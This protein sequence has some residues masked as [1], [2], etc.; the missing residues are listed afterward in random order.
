MAKSL[1][2]IMSSGAGEAMPEPVTTNEPA[3]I[4]TPVESAA[5]AVEQSANPV[6]EKPA[7][8]MVPLPALQ[9]AR[10]EAREAREKALAIEAQ[11]QAFTQMMA[12]KPEPKPVPD[13]F[14]DPNGFVQHALDPVQSQIREIREEMSREFAISRHGKETV[15]AAYVALEAGMRSRDPAANRTYQAM[16]QS[17]NP[18]EELVAWHKTN[19]ARQKYGEDPDAY[20]NAEIERRLAER[21]AAMQASGQPSQAA[22]PG[23]VPTNLAA[24]RSAGP[25]TGVTFTGPR[26]LSEIMKQR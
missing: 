5:L 9:E 6:A 23:L 20:I 14:V 16:M 10:R 13:M 24:A 25:R 3:A 18:Y 15:Q 8:T 17:G 4:T 21:T 12:P 11:L 2:D 7:D 19:T 26:P 22:Q 1:D